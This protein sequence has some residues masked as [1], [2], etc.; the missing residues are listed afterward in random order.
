LS[1]FAR[2]DNTIARPVQRGR[3]MQQ[4]I[5]NI[6][7]LC[8]DNARRDAIH[9]AVAPVVAAERVRPGQHVSLTLDKYQHATSLNPTQR[10]GVVDP[11]LREDVEQGQRFWLMLY[12]NTVT[13]LRHVWS[14][15][16]FAPKLPV[17]E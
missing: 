5:P 15:P 16:A 3:V 2:L 4:Y 14:H 10:V 7:E 11:F 17:K 13:S 8:H 6:G 9:F 1:F 12:P